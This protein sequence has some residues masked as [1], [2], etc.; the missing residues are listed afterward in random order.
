M[1]RTWGDA[2]GIPPMYLSVTE[3]PIDNVWQEPV[4]VEVQSWGRI[5]ASYR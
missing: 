5:K 2:L 3:N 1:V 4:P